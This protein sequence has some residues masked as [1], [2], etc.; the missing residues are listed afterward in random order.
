MPVA[1]QR[2]ARAR[3]RERLAHA[4]VTRH[5]AR[6]RARAAWLAV[7][8][9]ACSGGGDASSSSS[10]GSETDGSTTTDPATGDAS[11]SA[12]AMTTT[13]GVATT[14]PDT[15]AYTT[16]SSSE[17]GFDPPPPGGA[18]FLDVTA[19]VGIDHVQGEWNTSP[20]CIV[21]APAV[22]K[23]GHF[24]TVEWQT[25]GVAAGD[26][27]GDGRVDLFFPRVYGANLLYR[28]NGDGTFSERGAEAGLD[29]D[30][31]SAGAA[32]G[33]IDNDG[34][35]DLYVTA[36]G[37]TRHYLF[38]NDGAGGFSEQ[39][40]ARGAALS[41]ADVHTGTTP[42]F[43]D[44]DL[45]GY[46]DVYV[47][48]YRTHFAL[49]DTPSHSRLLRNLGADA[50][51][52]FEDVTD[53][54]GVNIDAVWKYVETEFPIGGTLALTPMFS[55]LDGDDY[56]ELLIAADFST[57]RL[58]WNNG[59]GT[60]TDGTL[61]AGV[62]T[63]E[64]GMG[65]A[66]GD[67]DNDADLDWLVTSI[68]GVAGKTGNHLYRYE[69]A[70]LFSDATDFAGVREGDWGWGV[71]FLDHDLDGDLDVVM[72]NGWNASNNL[73]DAMR[74]W[75]N[76]GDGAMV[77]I[78]AE[79]GTLDDG[80]GR[81]LVTLDHDA[82]GD[83]DI[84]VVNFAASPIFYRNEQTTQRG[85]LEVQ[86]V[87]TLSN[88]DGRGARVTVRATA[89]GPPQLREIGSASYMGHGELTAHFGLKD[90]R[91][92][93]AEVRVYWPASGIEQVLLDVPQGERLVVTE[94]P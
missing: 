54:A 85:W 31:H 66:V 15:G 21:D 22:D 63:D 58:F 46:L 33:D 68:S 28:N 10:T 30:A 94:S 72:T 51:G 9:L 29:L 76:A 7:A 43:G 45:D 64:N 41:S 35:L 11:T 60:F 47:G 48:E 44:Y 39:G 32:W 36:V 34:D 52:S 71:A 24:C 18:Y 16:G 53:A 79:V 93:V 17:T 75:D 57:S 82:D 8:L 90:H 4:T 49:G 14:E 59:D 38:I 2:H 26:Y 50:P 91:G 27:D 61:D 84:V 80:Q 20:D 88:R 87:G 89:D 55:D 5:A 78:S 73:F 6:A 65:A 42:S 70:R 86:A 23:V 74:F 67:F 56:P 3:S 37:G 1:R 62:G 40:E 83:L 12:G 81:G 92:P 69:G 77:E 13:T 19:E 25:G